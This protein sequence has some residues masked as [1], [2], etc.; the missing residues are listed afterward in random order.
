[1]RIRDSYKY[2]DGDSHIATIAKSLQILNKTDQI[3]YELNLLDDGSLRVRGLPYK[4][5]KKY[6]H[7]ML[8]IKPS[9]SNVIEI[10]HEH[11]ATGGD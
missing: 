3:M 4:M 11:I 2:L 6:Y 7:E 8:M 9:C 1:M 10:S 5:G